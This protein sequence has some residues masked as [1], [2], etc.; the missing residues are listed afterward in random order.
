MCGGETGVGRVVLDIG[1]FKLCAQKFREA[2]AASLRSIA[3]QVKRE[4]GTGVVL[5]GSSDEGKLSFV[6]AVTQDLVGR[7]A[8]A[9]AIARQVAQF[10]GGK[11]GGRKDFAQGGGP[12]AD[13]EEIVRRVA[14]SL[15]AG[16]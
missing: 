13:W 15:R 7:G 1:E 8:D 2:E 9:V 6:V 10:V 5:L 12:E 11:A 14:E 3:D 4:V 16:A